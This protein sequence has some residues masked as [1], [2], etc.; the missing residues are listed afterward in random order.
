M[1]DIENRLVFSIFN[2]PP[3]AGNGFSGGSS[4]VTRITSV[5]AAFVRVPAG[6]SGTGEN[7]RGL[8]LGF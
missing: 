3:Q 8:D 4:Q 5:V 7:L 1:L 2:Q 6:R